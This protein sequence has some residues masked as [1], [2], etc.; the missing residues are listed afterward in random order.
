MHLIPGLSAVSKYPTAKSLD[1]KTRKLVILI[2]NGRSMPSLFRQEKHQN[3]LRNIFRDL[4]P[5][6]E[7]QGQ[8]PDSHINF[9]KQFTIYSKTRNPLMKNGS[10]GKAKMGRVIESRLCTGIVRKRA[11]K[12]RPFEG[13][14]WWLFPVNFHW[15]EW[16]PFKIKEIHK[17]CI[18]E[19]K[20]VPDNISPLLNYG[21][22]LFYKTGL[23]KM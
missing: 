15:A 16:E 20:I 19:C 13:I 23:W 8:K 18:W 10:W 21:L 5:D 1:E 17:G 22:I 4:N 9:V 6:L 2:W 12:L 7:N 14:G 11:S 3:L